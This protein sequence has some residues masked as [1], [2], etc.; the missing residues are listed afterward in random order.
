MIFLYEPS[1]DQIGQKGTLD[2]TKPTHNTNAIF[3]AQWIH[4]AMRLNPDIP[5]YLQV[6]IGWLEKGNSLMDEEIFL[7]VAI[8][9]LVKEGYIPSL[10]SIVE[11]HRE[12]PPPELYADQIRPIQFS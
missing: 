5:K 1:Q 2:I 4:F 12:L 8:F 6:L 7:H 3:A 11:K 9:F 10:E